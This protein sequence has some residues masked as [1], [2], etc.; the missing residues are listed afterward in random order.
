MLWRHTHTHTHAQTKRQ[1]QLDICVDKCELV[2]QKKNQNFL[3]LQSLLYV[4][5]DFQDLTIYCNHM[6]YLT[7]HFKP[8]CY[9]APTIILL[10]QSHCMIYLTDHCKPECYIDATI[11]LPIHSDC[12]M[13]LT[14]YCKPECYIAATITLLIVISQLWTYPIFTPTVELY[15]KYIHTLK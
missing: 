5:I 11:I 3:T 7:D 1:C 9:I 6:M 12:M 2:R 15:I 8:E 10:I 4:A 14:D 13:Y